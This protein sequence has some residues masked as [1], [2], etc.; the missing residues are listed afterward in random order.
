MSNDQISL[1]HKYIEQAANHTTLQWSWISHQN[2]STT[3]HTHTFITTN[4]VCAYYFK[5]VEVDTTFM[6]Q[7]LLCGFKSPWHQTIFHFGNQFYIHISISF[8][9]WAFVWSKCLQAFKPPFNSCFVSYLNLT[10][11]FVLE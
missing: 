4:L 6:N 5:Q 11:N 10:Y 2:Q 3:H 9:I 8:R 7:P 1:L